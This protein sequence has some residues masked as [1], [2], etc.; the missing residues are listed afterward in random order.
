MRGR[1]PKKQDI[2]RTIQGI[3]Q[4]TAFLTTSAFSYSAYL[5][6]IGKHCGGYNFFTASYI[7][8]F[9]SSFT[10]KVQ[11]SSVNLKVNFNH[12]KLSNSY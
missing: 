9:M 7:P 8:A 4:S 10:G 3:F 2:L 5:C 12:L 6:S 1:I 11:V